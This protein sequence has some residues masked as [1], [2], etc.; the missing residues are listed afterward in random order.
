M[1]KLQLHNLVK[2]FI[3]V[4]IQGDKDIKLSRLKQDE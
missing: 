2:N 4:F 1:R 3:I